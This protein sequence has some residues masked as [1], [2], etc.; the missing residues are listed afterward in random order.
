[1]PVISICIVISHLPGLAGLAADATIGSAHSASA[2]A[3]LRNVIGVSPLMV[4]FAE[5]YTGYLRATR[6]RDFAVRRSAPV[7]AADSF[8]LLTSTTADAAAALA[9]MRY[10]ADT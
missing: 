4:G 7:S 3:I 1:M 5:E 10:V 2:I 6:V 9:S 8:P